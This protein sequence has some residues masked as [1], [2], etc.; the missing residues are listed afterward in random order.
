MLYSLEAIVAATLETAVN[1]KTNT[2]PSVSGL[3][4][5]I[6]KL[7]NALSAKD[8]K[9]ERAATKEKKL[10]EKMEDVFHTVA[11]GAETYTTL[12][13][14]SLSEGYWGDAMKPKGI[15]LRVGAGLIGEVGGL[16]LAFKGH[17]AAS[18]LTAV[19]RGLVGSGIA[20]AGLRHGAKIRE[21][22]K[23]KVPT[24]SD[25]VQVQIP[26]NAKPGDRFEVT[27]A[28]GGK[29]IAVVVQQSDGTLG[30]SFQGE[31]KWR[32][33]A[34]RPQAAL[35]SPGERRGGGGRQKPPPNRREEK[36]TFPRP[37]R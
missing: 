18:H 31:S 23:K 37:R 6:T 13:L 7:E 15:D 14:G 9:I 8:D 28:N 11:N 10:T 27:D 1:G 35:L 25:S 12:Y 4:S 32:E 34:S 17:K 30:V 26:D 16:Y 33:V 20:S 5:M 21:T 24:K 22:D 19:S 2:G 36:D 29:R 3:K